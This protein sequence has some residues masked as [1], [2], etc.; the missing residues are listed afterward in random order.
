MDHRQWSENDEPQRVIQNIDEKPITQSNL[1][2]EKYQPNGLW[3][4][5]VIKIFTSWN[6]KSH[7]GH[8]MQMTL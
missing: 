6:V 1:K 3:K 4:Y 8:Q 7:L 2:V 5:N